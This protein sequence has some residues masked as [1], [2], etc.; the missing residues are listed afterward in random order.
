MRM[1][2]Y[3]G[4]DNALPSVYLFNPCIIQISKVQGQQLEPKIIIIWLCKCVCVTVELVS[5][6]Y[7]KV[8]QGVYF[9]L[10]Y[11]PATGCVT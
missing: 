4:F 5:S 6:V 9:N 10:F 11:S 7:K 8:Q 2:I 3:H 1:Y